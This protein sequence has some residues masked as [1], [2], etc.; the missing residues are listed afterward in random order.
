M[1][2]LKAA[3][4]GV[5]YLGRF[6][7]Q[8]YAAIEDVDL[9][10]VVDPNEENREKVAQELKCK[11]FSSLEPILD[12]VDLVSISSAT[13]SHYELAKTCLEKRI[14]VLVEKPITSS[15]DEAEELVELAKKNKRVLQVGH[16]ERFNP[17]F[18]EALRHLDKPY[19]I[20]CRR[21]APF[22]PRG[23]D[24]NVIYDLMIHDL[25][26][27]IAIL[28]EVP[29][30]EWVWSKSMVTQEADLVRV[31]LS[32]NEGRTTIDIDSHRYAPMTQREMFLSQEGKEIHLDFANLKLSVAKVIGR[33]PDAASPIE[34]H[35]A[36]IAKTD[37]LMLEISDFVESVKEGRTPRVSGQDGLAAL[38]LAEEICGRL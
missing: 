35:E 4:I 19:Y 38:R 12:Q 20:D 37:P 30:V 23:V 29:R 24:V 6:H 31:R 13:K 36:D 26:L 9:Y 17:V 10:G 3:V 25:D 8:K 2:T 34:L 1:S 22:K 14:H 28:G 33:Y 21:I 15:A 16:I 7:A 18:N 32:A 5:G 27:V 11:S